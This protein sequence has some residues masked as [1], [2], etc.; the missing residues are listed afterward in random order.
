M[1]TPPQ[2]LN[3]ECKGMRLLLISDTHGKLS[4][5]QSHIDG[6]ESFQMLVYDVWG[7]HEVGMMPG[8]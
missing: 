4:E 7:N 2:V 6:L 1:E 8:C 5:F 3:K